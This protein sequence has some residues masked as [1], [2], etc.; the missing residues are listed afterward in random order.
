[1][2]IKYV[3]QHIIFE[4]IVG[5]QAYGTDNEFSDFD[6]SGVMI[7]GREYF[8]GLKSFEQFQGFKDVDKTIYDIRKALNL[9]A[10]N[11]PNML[12]LLYTP[13]RCIVRTSKFWDK[14]LENRD[15]FL[16]KRIRWTFSGYAIAQLNRIKTH[17]R[18]LLNPPKTKPERS[19]FN[20][21]ETSMFPTSQIKAVCQ[22]SLDIINECDREFF[23][24]ELD[25]IYSDYVVPLFMRYIIPE[26]RLLAIEWLQQGIKSQTNAFTSLGTQYLK[27]EYIEIAHRELQFYNASQEWKQYQDWKKTRNPKRADLEEKFGYDTKHSMHLVRLLR[28]GKEGLDTGILNVDRNKIDAEE[29]KEIRNGSWS[30]EK[31]EQYALDKDKELSNSYEISKLPKS[32]DR[33]RIS[34]LCIDIVNKFLNEHN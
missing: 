17:R 19:H 29:L 30:F 18:F 5:S 14:I 31:L 13:E 1:M 10:D 12:D 25:R 4:C 21:P 9:I 22:S 26:E 34:E 20:L 28:M 3:E 32:P 24:A 8:L 2:D 11:N 23:I 27:D 15:I 33:E 7:P 16:S 6:Y